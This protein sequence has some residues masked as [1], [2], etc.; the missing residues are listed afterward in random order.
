[1]FREALM[2]PVGSSSEQFTAFLTAE[3]G[4]WGQAVKVSGA[5]VD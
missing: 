2:E 4:R 3:I 5:K 1:M